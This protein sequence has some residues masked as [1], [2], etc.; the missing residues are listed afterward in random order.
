[1]SPL[2]SSGK[3]T[4]ATLVD[5]MRA[6][7]ELLEASDRRPPSTPTPTQLLRKLSPAAKKFMLKNTPIVHGIVSKT[8]EPKPATKR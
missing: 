3:R 6:S 5:K 7:R 2:T 4:K 1:M 8:R